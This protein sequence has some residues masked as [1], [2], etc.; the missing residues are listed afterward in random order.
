MFATP[1]TPVRVLYQPTIYALHPDKTGMITTYPVEFSLETMRR[2][3]HKVETPIVWTY[4]NQVLTLTPQG[5][6]KVDGQPSSQEG[7]VSEYTLV[8]RSTNSTSSLTWKD[9][10]GKN[11]YW[12]TN[13]MDKDPIP[14]NGPTF[15]FPKAGYRLTSLEA[16]SPTSDLNEDFEVFQMI[17]AAQP[18]VINGY[19]GTNNTPQISVKISYKPQSVPDRL[20]DLLDYITSH[21]VNIVSEKSGPTEATMEWIDP[22]GALGQLCHPHYYTHMIQTKDNRVVEARALCEDASWSQISGLL[23]ASV[24]SL[25]S[26]LSS[27]PGPDT[28]SFPNYGFQMNGLV[29]IGD[30]LII[31][32]LLPTFNNYSST[33]EVS[34][35]PSQAGD[36]KAYCDEVK[37]SAYYKKLGN[38]ES[39]DDLSPTCWTSEYNRGNRHI[40]TRSLLLSDKRFITAAGSCLEE[41][42]P[43]S[44]PVIKACVDSLQVR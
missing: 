8:S 11:F 1:S 3:E 28:L 13:S 5:S 30:P 39:K 40:Y 38:V 6:V 37:S 21:G 23:R 4:Q 17:G 14:T 18:G 22:D 31:R 33:I 29:W 19:V 43:R 42:W 27:S 35:A 15:R 7:E 32:M 25:S 36:V 16:Q 20:G 34:S 12:E 41:E 24:D 10:K 2:I 9:N 26:T 44:S